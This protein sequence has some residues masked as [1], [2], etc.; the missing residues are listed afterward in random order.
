M[1]ALSVENR[2]GI[3]PHHPAVEG[4]ERRNRVSFDCSGIGNLA[5][6]GDAAAIAAIWNC[7]IRSSDLMQSHGRFESIETGEA[8]IIGEG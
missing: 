1:R 2:T 8:S 5:M 3:G 7:V 6:P 4:I